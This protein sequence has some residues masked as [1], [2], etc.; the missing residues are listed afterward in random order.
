[1]AANLVIS[2][3]G[4]CDLATLHVLQGPDKG[5]TYQAPDEPVIIGRSSDQI[6]LTDN[7]ASRR[8]AEIRPANGAWILIDLNSSNGTYLNGQRIVT[9]SPLKHGDQ[10]KVGTTLLAFSG[11]DHVESFTGAQMIRDLVDLDLTDTPGG[12][13]ILSAVDASED[14]V[15]LQPPETADAVAAWHVVYKIAETIGTIED[16]K[17]GEYRIAVSLR[18]EGD[19]VSFAT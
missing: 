16:I 7:S 1:M 18:Y 12:S 4:V 3:L 15:I 9:P 11:Q 19:S 6:H 8:H 13:S 5:R 14:S 17:R 10:I 2:V